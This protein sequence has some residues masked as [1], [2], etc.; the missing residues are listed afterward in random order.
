MVRCQETEGGQ[1][2]NGDERLSALL[3]AEKIL[4][5][6]KKQKNQSASSV[7]VCRYFSVFIT[8]PRDRD[9]YGLAVMS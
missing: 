9:W 1:R 4:G 6:L 8:W 7:F 3:T 2:V 5:R